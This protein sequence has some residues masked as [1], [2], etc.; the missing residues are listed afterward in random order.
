MLEL[1]R[2]SLSSAANEPLVFHA[3]SI[4]FAVVELL[5]TFPCDMPVLYGLC[6]S[7]QFSGREVLV[8][9]ISVPNI[10]CFW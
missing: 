2:C 5:I 3:E 6:R 9:H 4:T 8:Y 7:T 1:V 10:S